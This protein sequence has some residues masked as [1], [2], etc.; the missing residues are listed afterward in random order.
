MRPRR[1][2]PPYLLYGLL[3]VSLGLEVYLS[4]VALF[5][6]R[7]VL[8]FHELLD[9]VAEWLVWYSGI[10]LVLGFGLIAV[11]LL[12]L[13]RHRKPDRLVRNDPSQRRMA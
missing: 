6:P 12:Y 2:H 7:Y 1:S 13:L 9:R 8:P 11:D 10:P 4:G 3:S 5:V